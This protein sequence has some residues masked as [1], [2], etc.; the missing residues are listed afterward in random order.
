MSL[1]I[2]VMAVVGV[3]YKIINYISKRGVENYQENQERAGLLKHCKSLFTEHSHN[4][5]SYLQSTITFI[6]Q[7]NRQ[8]VNS[9]ICQNKNSFS[10][11]YIYK[12]NNNSEIIHKII[13][14]HALFYVLAYS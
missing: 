11:I 13:I 3:K 9:H 10:I 1:S 8:E 14:V 5:T 2:R 7:L 4:S 12:K 6:C